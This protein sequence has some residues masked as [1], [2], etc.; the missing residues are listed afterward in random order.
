MRKTLSVA[1]LVIAFCCPVAAGII[2]N[3]PPDPDPTPTSVVQESTTTNVD[4][5]GATDTL[6]QTVL[7][8]AANVL[9]LL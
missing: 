8:V 6:T 1:V 5:S 4:D 2:H 3:P 9:P 7:V